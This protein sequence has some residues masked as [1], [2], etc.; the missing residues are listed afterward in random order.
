[1]RGEV[2][3]MLVLLGGSVVMTLVKIVV[4]RVGVVGRVMSM[5][6]PLDLSVE[7]VVMISSVVDLSDSSIGLVERVVSLDVVSLSALVRSLYIS[8]VSV[9]NFVLV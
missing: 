1:M 2:E 3:G 4:N 6:Q 9:M 7:P 5:S 8:R